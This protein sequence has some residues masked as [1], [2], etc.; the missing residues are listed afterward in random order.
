MNA[1]PVSLLPIHQNQLVR[2]T[3]D[4]GPRR[5]NILTKNGLPVIGLSQRF[6]PNP[7]C[8]QRL[9]DEEWDWADLIESLHD[10]KLREI[11]L[12]DRTYSPIEFYTSESSDDL[13]Q[14]YYPEEVYYL[15]DFK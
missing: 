7:R 6:L 13:L 15:C 2:Q 12:F 14:E 9:F 4:L 11:G 3:S 5:Q 10:V 1:I 8:D